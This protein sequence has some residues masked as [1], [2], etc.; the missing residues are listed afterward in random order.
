M[1]LFVLGFYV[2]YLGVLLLEHGGPMW[3]VNQGTY[4]TQRDPTGTIGYDGQFYYALALDPLGAAPHLDSPAYRYQRIL[5]PLVAWGLAFGRPA[6]VPYT[7]L[8]V[9]VVATAAAVWVLGRLLARDGVPAV[10]ALGFGL[11]LGQSIAIG[12]DLAEPLAYALVTL[13]VWL[14]HLGNAG[15][16]VALHVLAALTKETAVFFAL[17]EVVTAL[18]RRAWLDA[19]RFLA[20]LAVLLVW[21]I[22]LWSWLGRWPADE[23]TVSLIPLAGLFAEGGLTFAR[24]LNVVCIVVPGALWTGWIAWKLRWGVFRDPIALTLL[25][26]FA[27]MLMLQPKSFAEPKAAGRLTTGLVL[28]AILESR[29]GP[30]WLR[31]LTLLLWTVLTPLAL[32]FMLSR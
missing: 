22:V 14:R 15:G 23:P 12:Q 13:A 1:A 30:P 32:P 26:N 8:V 4:F 6:L 18:V 2:L 17:A 5:Y 28:A 29:H 3:F 24:W 9:N 31:L 27:F 20:P 7:L 10:F 19:F 25:G 21:Q 16:S 11:Y